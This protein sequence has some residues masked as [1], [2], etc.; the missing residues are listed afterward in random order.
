MSLTSHLKSKD[1]PVSQFF[2]NHF[3]IDEFLKIENSKLKN[4]ETILPSNETKYPW[5]NI[6]HITEYLLAI[7]MNLPFELLF[8]M[9]Y[10]EHFYNEK[11]QKIKNYGI[12]KK[13]LDTE[14]FDG[15]VSK[16]LYH[17]SCFEAD[18]RSK[19]NPNYNDYIKY[20]LPQHCIADLKRLYKESISQIPLFNNNDNDF[21]YNPTFNESL[22]KLIGGADADLVYEHPKLGGCLLDLKTTKNPKIEKTMIYQLLGYIAL[23]SVNSFNFNQMGLYLTRQKEVVIYDLNTF[24]K[25]YSDI[26]NV[27]S[28]R[29]KFATTL[30]NLQ[31]PN[32]TTMKPK[33]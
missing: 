22:T 23:D 1:S 26:E 6:G 12:N 30:F 10:L 7:N 17:L 4:L 3:H 20:Q 31:Y 29:I 13:H 32:M 5:S 19:P 15:I 27:S 28:L 16:T 14:H 33:V 11:Y 25:E 21:I 9:R 2:D 24:L 8:P 18:L